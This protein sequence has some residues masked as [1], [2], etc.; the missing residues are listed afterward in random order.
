MDGG[1]LRACLRLVPMCVRARASSLCGRTSLG[2]SDGSRRGSCHGNRGRRLVPP[3]LSFPTILQTF[4][5][6]P[7][8]AFTYLFLLFSGAVTVGLYFSFSL[9]LF[10]PPCHVFLFYFFAS[11][12]CPIFCTPLVSLPHYFFLLHCRNR[13][14]QSKKINKLQSRNRS[15][16]LYLCVW[17]FTLMIHAVWRGVPV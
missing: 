16:Y 13:Y 8:S 1:R 3:D 9:F 17:T 4:L 7:V 14:K 12:S 6:L 5:V 2:Q 15:V 11:T 10:Y